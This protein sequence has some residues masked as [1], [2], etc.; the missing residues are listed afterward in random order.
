MLDRLYTLFIYLYH[1]S[2]KPQQYPAALKKWFKAQ[3]GEELDLEN[4]KTFSE[5]IQ[6]L[7][8]YDSTKEKADL[9][10]KYLVR[11]WVKEKIG[12]EYL[13]PLLGVWSSFDEIDFDALPKQ[14]VLKTNHSSSWNIIVKDKAKLD[15]SD[16]KRKLNRW[17]KM[18]YTFCCGLQL[19]YKLIERRIIAE[20]YLENKDGLDDYKFL[21]FDGKPYYI[22]K[23]VGRFG[24]QHY[25]TF[26]DLDWNCQDFGYQYPI[27]DESD[28]KPECLEEMVR[29]ATILCQG[30]PHVRVDFYEVDGHVYF[31]EMTFTCCSGIDRFDPIEMDLK[32]GELIKLPEKKDII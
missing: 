23:D 15:L 22:W 3:T 25:R 1:K 18:D 27:L 28:K 31:G 2:L 26:Y 10:D 4:P 30:F 17:M 19:H 8:L 32:M 21:C 5:K 6:W 29:L 13:V 24:E 20:K 12:E 16:A 9:S 11:E 7:K 14:F